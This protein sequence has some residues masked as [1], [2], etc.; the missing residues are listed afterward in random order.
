MSGFDVS[1]ISMNMKR[2]LAAEGGD[3]YDP[4][5]KAKPEEVGSG[6]AEIA[7]EQ[8]DDDDELLALAAGEEEKEIPDELDLDTILQMVEEAPEVAEMDE[9]MLKSALTKLEKTIN[10]NVQMRI[11]YPDKPEKFMDSEVAVDEAIT[12]LQP[13]TAS[14]ELYGSFV[15]EGGIALLLSL[16]P[17]ENTDIGVSVINLLHDV[18]DVENVMED[19]DSF[20]VVQTFLDSNGPN[21]VIELLLKLDELSSS[22]DATAVFNAMEIFENL[23]EVEVENAKKLAT[24]TKLLFFIFEK[25]KK[26]VFDQTKLYATEIL[27]ILVQ[28]GGSEVQKAFSG[29][30]STHIVTVLKAIAR[31][32]R[33]DPDGGEETEYLENLFTALHFILLDNPDNQLRFG[34]A[35]GFQLMLAI[36]RKN[37]YA[38]H[39][40]LKTINFALQN[41]QPNCEKLVDSAGLK[42]LFAVLMK[43]RKKKER[44]FEMGRDEH[45]TSLL[46]QMF[47]HLSDV[48]YLRLLRKFQENDY[49][50]IERLVELYVLYCDRVSVGEQQ[51][52]EANPLH[53]RPK[54]RKKTEENKD[55]PDTEEEEAYT[56]RVENGLFIL[57]SV[58]FV[59][60]FVA[61]AGDSKLAKRVQQLLT[62]HD[63]SLAELKTVLDEYGAK[64]TQDGQEENAKILAVLAG[65]CK[66]LA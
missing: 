53:L 22:S 57:Q 2:K 14:P 25:L 31:Y 5:K 52:R 12:S 65:I 3:T 33:R 11:K 28:S 8:E 29:A 7:G 13:L 21:I 49:Q 45:I 47:I 56:R 42:V 44:K 6:V 36:I 26:E 41:C 9:A 24:E 23:V 63:K 35:E 61:T 60:G 50:K 62:Q 15:K 66:M 48:R 27:S 39:G 58:S 30:S 16:I 10:T 32:R 17:H 64:L 46:V 20:S 43:K 37:K 19:E 59:I 38:K 4:Y 54:R 40:A 55:D 18:F 1:S 51:W 34:K